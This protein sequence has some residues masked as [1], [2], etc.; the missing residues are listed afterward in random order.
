MYKPYDFGVTILI[1]PVLRPVI[2]LS[3]GIRKY[4]FLS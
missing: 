2:I 4:A 1:D 3:S